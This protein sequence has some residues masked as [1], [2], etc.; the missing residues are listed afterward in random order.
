MRLSDEDIKKFQE[1][2]K[3]SFGKEISKGD[4]LEK[5]LKLL[6][7]MKLVYVPM[8][9]EEYDSIQSHMR[10]TVPALLTRLHNHEPRIYFD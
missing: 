7:L 4:A 2:Y 3:T 10:K 1:L 9:Q 8:T 5:G 6:N